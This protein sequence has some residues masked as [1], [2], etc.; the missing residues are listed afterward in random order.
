M[1]N[2]YNSYFH[3]LDVIKHSTL[4]HDLDKAKRTIQNDE[5]LLEMIK[6]YRIHPKEE[7]KLQI[8]E[9]KNY[10]DFKKLETEVNILIM[11]INLKLKQVKEK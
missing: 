10:Q 5:K 3:L 6:E 9:N 4:K 1:E 11:Q 2:V 7:L 8:Y